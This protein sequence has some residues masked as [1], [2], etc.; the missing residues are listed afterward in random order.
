MDI[1]IPKEIE[2]GETRTAAVPSTVEKLIRLGARVTVEAGVGRT[3]FVTDD[4]YEQAGAKMSGNRAKSLGDTDMVLT[5]RRL[6]VEDI[7]LLKAG[8][9]LVGFL[10]P[11]AD[12]DWLQAVAAKGIT[13]VSMELMPRS[14]V[15]QKMDAISSQANLAGYMSVIL[16]AE[17]SIAS[18]P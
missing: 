14:T 7:S 1:F 4:A 15:A 16:G 3:I 9:L 10:D 11:F 18:C 6:P 5:L 13:S 17:N 8:A 12:R 2:P